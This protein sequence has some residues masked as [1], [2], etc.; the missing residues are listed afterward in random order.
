M[1]GLTEKEAT[2]WRNY[3]TE[4]FSDY[5]IE[6][7]DPMRQL[8]YMSKDARIDET[9]RREDHVR[10]FD[11]VMTTDRGINIRDYND[12]IRSDLIFINLLGA[13][14]ISVGTV[15]EIAWAYDR[16]IPTV[17]VMEEGNVHEHAMLRDMISYRVDT[18]DRGI[19]VVLSVLNRYDD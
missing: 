3:V 16:R 7:L 12:T 6:V 4:Y 13:R 17:L 11:P 8:R 15:V 14:K 10:S 1:A 19:R 5:G 18:L 9:N 2:E